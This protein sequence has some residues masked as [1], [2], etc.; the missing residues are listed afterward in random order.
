MK[1]SFS[2]AIACPSTGRSR[3]RTRR[4]RVAAVSACSVVGVLA[5][6]SGAMASNSFATQY[7]L[8]SYRSPSGG[9]SYSV[10]TVNVQENT[11]VQSGYDDVALQGNVNCTTSNVGIV[12]GS[13]LYDD[14]SRSVLAVGSPFSPQQSP[15]A[16]SFGSYRDYQAGRV[17]FYQARADMTLPVGGGWFAPGCDGEFTSRLTCFVSVRFPSESEN[18][19]DGRSPTVAATQ[20]QVDAIRARA[21]DLGGQAEQQITS[22]LAEVQRQVDATNDPTNTALHQVTDAADQ[23]AGP[24]ADSAENTVDPTVSPT[25]D[26]AVAQIKQL[27]PIMNGEISCAATPLASSCPPVSAMYYVGDD[28]AIVD[29]TA[30]IL[31]PLAPQQQVQAV[32]VPVP[33]CFVR[34]FTPSNGSRTNTQPP[35]PAIASTAQNKCAPTV[36][37]Q[38]LY[39]CLT[40]DTTIGDRPRDCEVRRR[41]GGGTIGAF[42]RAGCVATDS[43]RTYAT[44]YAV[45]QD[46]GFFAANRS[47]KKLLPCI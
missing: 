32:V 47:A 28:G 46:K 19:Q 4:A 13:T 40:V 5:S 24:S 12:G 9:T 39:A 6:A 1:L 26:Q 21:N 25:V 33:Q 15:S 42:M 37:Y 30:R 22:G 10:C 36:P 20:A 29:I 41:A 2:S 23:A 8:G 11:A 31:G 16:R 44:G 14:A 7:A 17:K 3:A 27:A 45:A 34:G 18:L 43:W 35:K 38:E